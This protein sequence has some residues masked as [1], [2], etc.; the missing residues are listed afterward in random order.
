MLESGLTY[1]LLVLEYLEV[2]QEALN[3]SA[4]NWKLVEK[5]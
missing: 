2:C 1:V 3:W 5:F 4:D